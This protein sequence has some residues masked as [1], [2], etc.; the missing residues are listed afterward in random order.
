MK[1]IGLIL[2]TGEAF[3]KD[4]LSAL[5]VDETILKHAA[6]TFNTSRGIGFSET[7]DFW[8]FINS[9]A[10]E[11][12]LVASL[13]SVADFLVDEIIDKETSA[14]EVIL[15]LKEYCKTKSIPFSESWLDEFQKL[16]EP[17]DAYRRRRKAY[18]LLRFAFPRLTSVECRAELHT[19]K[20]EKESITIPVCT[21]KLKLR[22]ESKDPDEIVAFHVDGEIMAELADA[23][24][25]CR[26]ELS[27]LM[28]DWEGK[29]NINT[30]KAND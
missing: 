13:L 25:K 15:E 5:K 1:Q 14:K 4:V 23:I 30:I 28:S 7:Q 12:K 11:P 9:N 19:I 17:K 3:Q 16:I 2:Q 21:L 24:S 6:A 22:E 26:E 8:K 27:V 18:K 20:Q 10:A 29:T